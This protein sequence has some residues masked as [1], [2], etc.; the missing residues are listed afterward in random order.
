MSKNLIFLHI[1]S[2]IK[3]LVRKRHNEMTS[4]E[5]MISFGGID[6]CIN[7]AISFLKRSFTVFQGHI[8]TH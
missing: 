5:K 1:G 6:Q 2:H 8:S 4:F 3:D 7:L